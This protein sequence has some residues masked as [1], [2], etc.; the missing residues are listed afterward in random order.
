MSWRARVPKTTKTTH[1]MGKVDGWIFC[2]EG[3]RGEAVW[4]GLVDLGEIPIA[5]VFRWVCMVFLFPKKKIAATK[6][7]YVGFVWFFYWDY[8]KTTV[9]FFYEKLSNLTII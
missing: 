1:R 7:F 4:F 8:L 3:K 9:R 2:L 5:K 6:G